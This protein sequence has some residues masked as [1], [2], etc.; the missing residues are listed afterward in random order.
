MA[1]LETNV[2]LNVKGQ[3]FCHN[4]S[5]TDVS[6]GETI[7]AAVSGKSHYVRSIT[8][9]C[10][11]AITAWIQDNTGTPVVILGP[12]SF[13]DLT[14]TSSVSTSPVTVN[15]NPPVKVTAG[16]LIEIDASGAGIVAGVIQGFTE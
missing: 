9:W 16:K 1:A 14:A 15:F 5:G 7:V 6:T 8:L 13:V 3:G 4:F 10:L 11:V 12:V 2:A